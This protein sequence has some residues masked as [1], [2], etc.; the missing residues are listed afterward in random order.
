[1]DDGG[2]ESADC[3]RSVGMAPLSLA[4]LSASGPLVR[5]RRSV[6]ARR[7]LLAAVLAALAVLASVRAVQGPAAPSEQVVVAA[8]DL[9]G[10]VAVAAGDLRVV[11]FAPDQAPAGVSHD[12]GLVAGRVLAAPV[13]AGEPVTDV[14]LVA[15]GLLRGYPGSVA[16]PVRLADA[17]PVGLLRVGD[18]VEVLAADP[19]GADTAEVVV[20]A[21]VLAL[22]GPG[23]GSGPQLGGGLG[24]A[25]SAQ[26]GLVVLAVPP[27]EAGRLAQAAVT[28]VLSVALVR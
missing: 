21:P 3:L 8:R 12:P 20:R 28:H 18:T 2:T 11:S 26:G 6:L 27:G 24:A 5:L 23:S 1:M 7:R 17:G 13:R 15:P 19:G 4:P 10:G 16:L 25:P 14:R 9:A 22:P